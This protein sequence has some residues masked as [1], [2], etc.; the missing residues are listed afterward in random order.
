MDRQEKR[1]INPIASI[2]LVA[3]VFLVVF[4]FLVIG[5]MLELN[6][7]TVAKHAPWAYEP[8][9]RLVGE[10]PESAPRRASVEES[11]ETESIDVSVAG[12]AGINPSAVPVLIETDATERASNMILEATVPLEVEPEPTPVAVPTNRPVE[13]PQEIVPVG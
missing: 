9:L 3:V 4:E 12:V 2:T 10:H 1:R 7:Q 5:G 8:F 13:K 6:A 11:G